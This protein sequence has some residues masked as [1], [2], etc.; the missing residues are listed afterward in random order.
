MNELLIGLVCV[1]LSTNQV[2]AA[3]NLV[4][5]TTGVALPVLDPNDP[6]EKEYQKLLDED[7]QAQTEVDTWIKADDAVTAELPGAS[8]TLLRSRIDR[9]F[10]PVIKGYEDFLLRHSDHARARLAYGSF[11]NDIGKEDEALVQWEK[12]RTLEPKNP[13]AWNNLANHFSHRGPVKKSFEYFA[14]AIELNPKEPVYYQNLATCVFL[15]R[16]DAKEYYQLDDDQKVFRR[17]LGL[18]RQ[19]L[20]LD[21]E[22]FALATDLAQTYYYLKPAPTE[23]KA[24]AAEAESKLFDEGIAAWTDAQKR[25]HDNLE[26]EGVYIHMAR[27]S[28][29]AKRFDDARKY[30]ASVKDA[31]YDALKKRLTRNIEEK[32]GAKAAPAEKP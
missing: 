26:R 9:R 18:Y 7:D 14:K 3:S 27:L 32:S 12:A 10:E 2:A 8:S 5:H 16:K 23:D 11:L 29:A 17:A 20:K 21:P 31:S 4:A 24:S 13:A 6:V 28:I 25:A 30:L 1:M 22:N 19:A 15:F